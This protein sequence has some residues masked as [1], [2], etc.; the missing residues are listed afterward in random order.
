LAQPEVNFQVEEEV[1]AMCNFCGCQ[2]KTGQ[3]YGG[4]KLPDST[5]QHERTESQVEQIFEYGKVTNKKAAKS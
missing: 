3:G 4:R 5:A 1:V 2:T